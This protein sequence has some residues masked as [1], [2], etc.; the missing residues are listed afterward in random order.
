MSK[1]GDTPVTTVMCMF[2]QKTPQ[3]IFLDMLLK[4]KDNMNSSWNTNFW[5]II[6]ER[7]TQ[8]F[9]RVSRCSLDVQ[10]D[11]IPLFAAI[12]APFDL[13]KELFIKPLVRCLETVRTMK[14]LV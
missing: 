7:C 4:T 13:L 9:T 11:Q 2:V 1:K 5:K 8:N 12:L 6:G 14:E 3:G 10:E